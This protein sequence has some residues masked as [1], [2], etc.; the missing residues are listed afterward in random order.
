MIRSVVLSGNLILLPFAGSIYG[1]SFICAVFSLISSASATP[2][3]LLIMETQQVVLGRGF[4]E[5]LDDIEHRG[6]PS[7]SC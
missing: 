5:A 6:R 2:V 3:N 4:R 1:A 7:V